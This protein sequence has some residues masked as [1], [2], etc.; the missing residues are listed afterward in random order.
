MLQAVRHELSVLGPRVTV[1]LFS[2]LK[3][4]GVEEAERI[5]GGWL[6]LEAEPVPAAVQ[7]DGVGHETKTPDQGE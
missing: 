4:T 2:S 6:G 1:Q 5:V 7:T 3:R